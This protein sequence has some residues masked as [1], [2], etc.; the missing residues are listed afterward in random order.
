MAGEV[1]PQSDVSLLGGRPRTLHL[2][3]LRKQWQIITLQV[4]ATIA[5]V[6]MY[7]E[8]VSTYVVNSID[9]T[10]VFETLESL[11][12]E[13]PIGDW[14]TGEGRQ[15]LAR[16][17]VPIILGLLLGGS[18]ALMAFQ[19]P[20]LQQRIKLGFIILLMVS[21]V[22]RL[23]LTWVPSMIFSLDF[24]APSEGE[25]KTLEWPLLMILS[26]VILFVYLLPVIMGTRGIW[27]LSRRSIGWAIG[28]TLLFLG[29]HAIL[30]FPLI[31]SQL[32]DWG[33]NLKTL[34]TQVSDP[35]IGIFGFDLVTPEQL[36]LILIAVLIMVFQESG[37][38]VIRYLEYAY[39]LPESCK[40]DPE[41]VKQMDNVL[42]GHLRHTAGFLT[43]TGLMTMI[44][45]GFHSVLLEVVSSSTGSQW[46]A[47][48][49]ESIELSLTY[50]LVISALLFL[51]L[52]A[53]M[54][55]F[56]PWERVWGLIESLGN[57]TEAPV[58]EKKF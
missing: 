53:V 42:N 52:I 2:K 44:A 54:R 27:G 24:R 18:M 10:M 25:L 30:T 3:M 55:F 22:G 12:G 43:I 58:E 5:L 16:F 32:G 36:S 57:K 50:G 29:I 15:G 13:V 9:H 49:S 8:V 48:V 7:L 31:K 41:Y 40:R 56:I 11:V 45:L 4:V 19:S 33:A 23:L 28:F 38:G 46:A 6:W 21:L 37:F 17:Y 14:I 26:L 1:D 20:K 47:Q 34:E 39:R 35:T 51:S